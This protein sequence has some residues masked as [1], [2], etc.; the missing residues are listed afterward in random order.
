[1]GPGCRP[2]ALLVADLT[3]D[4]AAIP[5]SVVL[6]L[7]GHGTPANNARFEAIFAQ[8][9]RAMVKYYKGGWKE[10]DEAVKVVEGYQAQG[11]AL[12]D[13]GDAIRIALEEFGN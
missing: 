9:P 11:K 13:R 8:G 2:D 5:P 6:S 7:G 1:M 12:G 3:L 4:P 10:N